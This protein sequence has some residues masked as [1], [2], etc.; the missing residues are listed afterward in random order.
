MNITN[1]LSANVSTQFH[2]SFNGMNKSIQN[3][4]LKIGFSELRQIP[5]LR[6]D[7]YRVGNLKVLRVSTYVDTIK[8]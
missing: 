4:G 7:F 1:N 3:T 2:A 8:I 6:K 5:Y